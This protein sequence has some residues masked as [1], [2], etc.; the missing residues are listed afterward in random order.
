MSEEITEKV[1]EEIQPKWAREEKGV[2][3]Y[4]QS[5]L[6]AVALTQIT[7]AIS[8]LRHTLPDGANMTKEQL[9]AVAYD[10]VTTGTMPGR[11]VHYFS[12]KDKKTG[13][14]KLGKVDD[15][16]LL[17]RWGIEKEQM[18]AGD[19]SA[20]VQ[21]KYR[22][23]TDEERT[24]EKV[25]PNATAVYCTLLSSHRDKKEVKEWMATGAT[26][27][28]ALD[29]V[30]TTAVGVVKADDRK[31]PTGWTHGQKAR[32]LAQKNAYRVR[33]GQPSMA[34]MT[35]MR[36]RWAEKATPEDWM[37]VE[38]SLPL[39][40]QTRMARL[41]AANREWAAESEANPLTAEEHGIRLR[42]N[43]D[44][45]RGPEE[46]GIGDD[47]P[48]ETLAELIDRQ[49]SLI[50]KTIPWFGDTSIIDDA[51]DKLGIDFDDPD[52][53][54]KLEAWGSTQ[55]DKVAAQ[56]EE[57]RRQANVEMAAREEYEAAQGNMF[58]NDGL[59]F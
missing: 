54:T 32:K 7:E 27:E 17:R 58:D 10:A 59:P 26:F 52:L 45:I 8:I 42:K 35:A 53:V 40:A 51:M 43:A 49:T 44:L 46:V 31:I 29:L 4:D 9:G 2:A 12:Y 37:Q 55:A 23:L 50:L 20:T 33:Y 3:L 28:Q 36:R 13:T 41:L 16:K 25:P 24:K 14:M 5:A 39:E 57:G 19:P 22:D 21:E 18:I 56:E 11:E 34:E 47:E 15:Y 6:G 30:G 1:Q 48:V 38:Q